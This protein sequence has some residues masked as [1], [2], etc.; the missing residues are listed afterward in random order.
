[1]INYPQNIV[2]S[3]SFDTLVEELKGALEI[4]GFIIS[5]ETDFQKDLIERVNVHY[6]KHK[7]LTVHYPA[8][9]FQMLS[10]STLEVWVLPCTVTI[11]EHYPGKVEVAC[12][13][14]TAVLAKES[15][16]V[17]LQNIAA[18]VGHRLD[19]LLHSLEQE[20]NGT[21]DMVTSWG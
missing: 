10:A 13:N 3:I 17:S 11:L 20:P 8:L 5:G 21:H 12:F 6:K 16:D 2:I 4:E 1:M 15:G 14:P 9:T 18:D 19:A 7:V